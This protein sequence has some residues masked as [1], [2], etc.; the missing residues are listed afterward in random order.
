MQI[1]LNLT[2][3]I[4]KLYNR[5]DLFDYK[6][7]GKINIFPNLDFYFNKDTNIISIDIDD[8][9]KEINIIYVPYTIGK[10]EEEEAYRLEYMIPSIYFEKDL[11]DPRLILY[12]PTKYQDKNQKNIVIYKNN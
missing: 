7:S 3:K 12:K 5:I 1:L 8:N 10:F 4:P 2:N 9:I 6:G 11:L